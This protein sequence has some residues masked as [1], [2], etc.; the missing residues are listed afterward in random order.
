M[1]QLSNCIALV[2]LTFFKQLFVKLCLQSQHRCLGHGE[3][4]NG[5]LGTCN[6]LVCAILKWQ[7]TVHFASSEKCNKVG[8]GVHLT[9]FPPLDS[10]KTQKSDE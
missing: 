3:H 4:G 7:I 6:P 9:S 10:K 8:F 1:I 2:S 5:I